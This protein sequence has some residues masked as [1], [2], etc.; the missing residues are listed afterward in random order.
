MAML[1]KL[2]WYVLTRNESMRV[3]SHSLVHSQ[4]ELVVQAFNCQRIMVS[5]KLREDKTITVERR[6]LVC[7]EW[8]FYPHLEEP[9]VPN[10]HQHQPKPLSKDCFNSYLLVAQLINQ[11]GSDWESGTTKSCNQCLTKNPTKLYKGNSNLSMC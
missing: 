8:Q 2:A 11:E 3:V 5:E 6:L 4:E 10:C 7:W 1:S 9:W